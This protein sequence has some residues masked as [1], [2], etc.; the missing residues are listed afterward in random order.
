MFALPGR[1]SDT[2]SQ[3]C[4]RLITLCVAKLVQDVDDII[5]DM[6]W[7]LK[8]QRVN[9]DAQQS[10]FPSLL[11]DQEAVARYLGEHGEAQL[12]RLSVE[13]DIPVGRLMSALIELEFQGLVTAF[14]GGTY[15]KA[16]P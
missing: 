10:L 11:P 16:V 9:A 5:E 14:P 12:N 7:P 6:N 2:Y 15:R 3:G 13:L 1:I 8:E 4:N